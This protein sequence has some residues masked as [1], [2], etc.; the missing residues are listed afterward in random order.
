MV[1]K[2]SILTD[3]KTGIGDFYVTSMEVIYLEHKLREFGFTPILYLNGS[4]ESLKSGR[5]P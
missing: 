4:Q 1:Q 2:V 5:V 3:F